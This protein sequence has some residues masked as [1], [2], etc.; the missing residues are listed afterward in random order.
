MQNPLE[1]VVR[2]VQEAFD[3]ALNGSFY[4]GE[5]APQ[6]LKDT[7]RGKHPFI[8]VLEKQYGSI[9][10]NDFLKYAGRLVKICEEEFQATKG[11]II[12]NNTHNNWQIWEDQID[13]SQSIP[14]LGVA[15][16]T[17]SFAN[18]LERHF[19][20][21][22]SVI[23]IVNPS[24][25]VVPS[26]GPYGL[27]E[28]VKRLPKKLLIYG[29]TVQSTGYDNFIPALY[30]RMFFV[31]GSA[32]TANMDVYID[33]RRSHEITGGPKPGLSNVI[34]YFRGIRR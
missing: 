21:E 27:V 4:H 34:D 22:D 31:E 23:L 28:W 3:Q 32:P 9:S 16:Q 17:N 15:I 12:L 8:G 26:Y 6:V 25:S 13:S 11:T 10:Y 33:T 5:T 2:P 14:H 29:T 19:K 20:N 24:T 30:S 7:F 18:N 1:R